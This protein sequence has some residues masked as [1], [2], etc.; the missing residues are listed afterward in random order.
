MQYMA[1]GGR[2]TARPQLRKGRDRAEHYL[3]RYGHGRAIV[4]ARLVSVVRTVLDPL[5]GVLAGPARTIR[6][7]A[8]GRWAVWSLGVVLAGDWLAAHIDN[9][10]HYLL[11]II[12]GVLIVSLLPIAAEAL[13]ARR[14]QQGTT[15]TAAATV[16][17]RQ[18]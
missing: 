16:D 5:A 4:V 13:R 1:A 10:D 14:R 12:A 11:S 6:R 17:G 7:V 3:A 15:T 18:Q 8:G 2:S 9:V